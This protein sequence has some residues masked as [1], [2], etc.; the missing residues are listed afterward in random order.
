M[1]KELEGIGSNRKKLRTDE[2]QKV[3][4]DRPEDLFQAQKSGHLSIPLSY[5][6]LIIWAF[7]LV[8]QRVE[9]NGTSGRTRTGTSLRTRD[10]E[11]LMSTNF[12]TLAL[13][14]GVL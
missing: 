4:G 8:P 12:I 7:S 10:F 5:R 3:T 6:A 2:A 14:R 13:R 9:E 11:S 1:R